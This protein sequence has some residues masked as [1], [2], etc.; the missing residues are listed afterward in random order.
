VGKRGRKGEMFEFIL[1]HTVNGIAHKTI[2]MTLNKEIEP[3]PEKREEEEGRKEKRE[4]RREAE[5]AFAH[6]K[7]KN[8]HNSA[9]STA[10]HFQRPQGA[11]CC[12][13]VFLH[14]QNGCGW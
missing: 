5:V 14:N 4:E 11:V 2:E 12:C 3:R 6:L 10:T 1:E 9:C 7:Q 13:E 8:D